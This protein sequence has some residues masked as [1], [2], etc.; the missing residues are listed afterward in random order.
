MNIVQLTPGA[1]MFCGSCMRD[2]ALI[3][4]L[5][6]LGHSTLLVPLYLPLQTDEPDQ[7]AGKPVFFGG[8]N[9][10]LQQKRASD[11]ISELEAYLKAFPDTPFAPQARD[12]LKRL[13]GDASASP[14]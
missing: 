7:S 6:K 14:Q 8:V 10:Y 11:A 5:Q 13:Q 1:G 3:S 2:N 4:A 12:L 9:L